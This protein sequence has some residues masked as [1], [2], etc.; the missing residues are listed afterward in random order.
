P[1]PPQP[2]PGGAHEKIRGLRGG[3]VPNASDGRE[4]RVLTARRNTLI[5]SWDKAGVWRCP[6]GKVMVVVAGPGTDSVIL[7]TGRGDEPRAEEPG[8]A[9][10]CGSGHER[11]VWNFVCA[12]VECDGS[13]RL[14][15][16]RLRSHGD[17][18]LG[19]Q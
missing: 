6:H 16:D 10:L 5:S 11:Q 13:L 14:D 7:E 19:R 8:H 4:R 2:R 3:A 1:R 15:L 18:L 17:S 12:A 9:A